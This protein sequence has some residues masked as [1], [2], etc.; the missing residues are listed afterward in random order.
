MLPNLTP[1]MHEFI[2]ARPD[3]LSRSI[4]YQLV[5]LAIELG[6][7]VTIEQF[8][9]VPEWLQHC[10][11]WGDESDPEDPT[12]AFVFRKNGTCFIIG[13]DGMHGDYYDGWRIDRD[14]FE[15]LWF[16]LFGGGLVNYP[17]VRFEDSTIDYDSDSIEKYG[18]PVFVVLPGNVMV[19]VRE[20]LL[21]KIGDYQFVT[22]ELLAANPGL[23]AQYNVLN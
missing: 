16:T 7:V 21:A 11:D 15:N 8:Q 23:I 3:H 18:A 6:W 4:M 17:Y 2:E 5:D 19:K 12:K 9:T 20:K 10:E 13:E 14:A 22:E 1:E